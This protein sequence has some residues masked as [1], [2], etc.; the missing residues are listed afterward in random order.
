MTATVERARPGREHIEEASRAPILNQEVHGTIWTSNPCAPFGLQAAILVSHLTVCS[1]ATGCGIFALIGLAQSNL[2]VSSCIS[3]HSNNFHFI[4]LRM[5][6]V[7]F[8]IFCFIFLQALL[9]GGCWGQGRYGIRR[10]SGRSR[11]R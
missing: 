10:H 2:F 1:R 4:V 3:S 6:L 7:R 9:S 8:H 11:R 5:I